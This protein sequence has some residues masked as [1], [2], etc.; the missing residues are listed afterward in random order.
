MLSIVR[1]NKWYIDSHATIDVVDEKHREESKK[2]G[3]SLCNTPKAR[4]AIWN[5]QHS[6][7][8]VGRLGRAAELCI[9]L[10]TSRKALVLIF[11][12]EDCNAIVLAFI[13]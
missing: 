6:D 1:W 7:K 13:L 2:G 8:E 3:A 10:P 11:S 9:P 12:S 5:L 4:T